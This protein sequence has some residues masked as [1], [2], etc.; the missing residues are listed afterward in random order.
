MVK[1]NKPEDITG[2]KT[3]GMGG[4]D[5]FL[6]QINETI[7]NARSLL[8][9]AADLGLVNRPQQT[10]TPVTERTQ[11]IIKD[12][13]KQIA[14]PPTPGFIDFLDN[15]CKAGGGE[16]TVDELMKEMGPMKLSEILEVVKNVAKLRG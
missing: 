2:T 3:P 5:G 14:A 10:A 16:K 12:P 13:P 8:K 6:K 11:V 9:S 1:I 15:I 7:N 4:T